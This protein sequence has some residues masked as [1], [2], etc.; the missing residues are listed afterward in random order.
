[1]NT[2]MVEQEHIFKQELHV[3]AAP[4]RKKKKKDARPSSATAMHPG[5]SQSRT[6]RH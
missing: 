4:D 3:Q 1:M 6:D 5:F 2:N